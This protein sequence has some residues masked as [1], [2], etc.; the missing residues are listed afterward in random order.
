[1]ELKKLLLHAAE[2]DPD[3]C[4]KLLRQGFQETYAAKCEQNMNEGIVAALIVSVPLAMA[5]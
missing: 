4:F 1:M 3:F 2:V 5:I